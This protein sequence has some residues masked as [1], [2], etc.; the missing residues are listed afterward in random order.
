MAREA[1]KKIY[2]VQKAALKNA[3]NGSEASSD[4][5]RPSVAK[6]KEVGK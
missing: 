3:G 5:V 4:D 1:H 6:H 2:E